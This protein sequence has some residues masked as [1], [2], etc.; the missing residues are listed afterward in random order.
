M[1]TTNPKIKIAIVEDHQVVRKALVKMLNDKD[2][3]NVLVEASNGQEFLDKIKVSNVDV[4]L[5]DLEMPIMNGLE[6]VRELKK[7][8]STIKI[9]MLTM[10]EENE[11]I[12]DLMTEGIDAYLLKECSIEEMEDAIEKVYHNKAYSNPQM[13]RAVINDVSTQRKINVRKQQFNLT[14]RDLIV[15]KMIC[16]GRSSEDISRKLN[17][18]KKNVDL[19]RTKIM[20]KFNVKTAVQ[21]FRA[22]ILHGFYSPRTDLEIEQEILNDINEANARRLKKRN[23]NN[24]KNA[25]QIEIQNNEC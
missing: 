13:N 25:E 11:I 24:L 14:D 19:M 6:T 1:S 22:V 9:V 4:V 5:L 10:F 7:I 23:E 12:F 16:D 2:N 20:K 18:S 21:L 15:I 8:G 3:F 17:T